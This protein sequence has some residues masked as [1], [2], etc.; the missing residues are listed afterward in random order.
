MQNYQAWTIVRGLDAPA[1]KDAD[2]QRSVACPCDKIR[3]DHAA[4]GDAHAEGVNQ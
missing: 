1:L 3:E 2:H 4:P